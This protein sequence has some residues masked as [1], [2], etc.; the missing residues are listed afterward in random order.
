M[1]VW[2]WQILSGL[3]FM[4]AFLFAITSARSIGEL[5]ALSVHG[6]LIPHFLPKYSQTLI[7]NSPLCCEHLLAVSKMAKLIYKG[8]YSVW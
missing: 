7:Y 1:G 4:N 8:L 6:D 5:Q 2:S 3:N